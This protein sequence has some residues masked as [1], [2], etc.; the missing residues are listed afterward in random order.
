MDKQLPSIQNDAV[1]QEYMEM[2]F[3]T[4]KKKEFQDT[5]ELLQYIDNMEKQFEEVTKELHDIK[6]L[7]NGLQNP[8]MRSRLTDVVDKTQIVINDGKDK[9]NMLKDNVIISMKDCFE[10][11]KKRSKDGVIK[12]INVLH[13]KEALGGI[14]K[15]LF[16]AMNKTN[17]IVHTCDAMTSELRNAK[18]NFKNVGLLMLGRPAQK[19]NGDK[20]KLNL[21]QKS[22]RS[23]HSMLERMVV[24]TTRTL[25]KLE[26]FE[27]PSV[28]S[29][30][31]LLSSQSKSQDSINHKKKEQ[32][33]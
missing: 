23:I 25:H 20:A 26:N 29:E 14:R 19:D 13:F 30:I 10:A 27:K 7:L 24:K 21:M 9:L 3:R 2:L 11:F 6:E 17:D 22:S 18:R 28:K 5:E 15:S 31:K 8:T 33:R 12:T 32:S 16:I 1:V 4:N